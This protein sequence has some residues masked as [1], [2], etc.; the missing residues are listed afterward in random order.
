MGVFSAKSDW[1]FQ[2][3]ASGRCGQPC[4]K[5]SQPHRPTDNFFRVGSDRENRENA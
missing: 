4:S 1:S 2:I 5:H 3:T